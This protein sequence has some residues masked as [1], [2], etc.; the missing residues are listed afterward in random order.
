MESGALLEQ[1]FP[2]IAHLPDSVR[3]ILQPEIL[4]SDP[5]FKL[6]PSDRSGDRRKGLGPDAI[7]GGQGP[8]PGVLIVVHKDVV[9]G[10]AGDAVF[11]GD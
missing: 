2:Q 11:G 10:P 6:F 8:T 5:A 3:D 1:R 7:D 4:N 9:F